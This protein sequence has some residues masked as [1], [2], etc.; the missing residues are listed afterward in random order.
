M[1]SKRKD[2][3]YSE[4]CG[5]FPDR[6]HIDQGRTKYCVKASFAKALSSQILERTEGKVSIDHDTLYATLLGMNIFKA[7]ESN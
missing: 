3:I 7:S 6:E 4:I 2:E 1:E 5:A